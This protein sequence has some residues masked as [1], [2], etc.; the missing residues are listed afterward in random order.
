MPVQLEIA[1]VLIYIYIFNLCE[2]VSTRDYVCKHACHSVHA[3]ARGQLGKE[4][5][6]SSLD[7]GDQSQVSGPCNVFTH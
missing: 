6:S 3:E 2:N 7:F 1:V 4:S 5:P